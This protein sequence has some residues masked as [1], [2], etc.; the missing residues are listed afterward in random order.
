ML[1]QHAVESA[2]LEDEIAA[3]IAAELREADHRVLF[4]I[5]LDEAFQRSE[6]SW[7][8]DLRDSRAV[9][10]FSAWRTDDGYQKALAQLLT[11]LGIPGGES[12]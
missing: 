3:G 8:R 1:S 6:A 5:S 9:M 11:K 2:W 4:L 10:D 7:A 12:Q